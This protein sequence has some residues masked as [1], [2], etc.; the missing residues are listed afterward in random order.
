M[1]DPAITIPA[2]TYARLRSLATN[3]APACASCGNSRPPSSLRGPNA[4]SAPHGPWRTPARTSAL[5]GLTEADVR[6]AQR[7]R[8]DIAAN[9]VG[10]RR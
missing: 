2:K 7:W 4:P 5:P 1:W 6:Q 9:L 3:A 10:S 8:A